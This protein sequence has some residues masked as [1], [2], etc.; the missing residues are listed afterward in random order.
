MLNSKEL[1]DKY[2]G[3]M[4]PQAILAEA[5]WKAKYG[6]EVE[7]GSTTACLGA[8]VKEE[9]KSY[10][11]SCQLGDS[12][13]MII[14]NG[15]ALKVSEPGLCGYNAP[16]QLAIVPAKYGEGMI[17]SHP[18]EAQNEVGEVQPGDVIV[19]ATDGLW[20]NVDVNEVCFYITILV[21]IDNIKKII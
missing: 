4:S 6:N 8:L 11:V 13:Y 16:N 14:R 5:Y 10:F 18:F 2:P 1:F 15:E 12:L 17:Q 19:M 7:V 9:E 21:I 20:D 3:V